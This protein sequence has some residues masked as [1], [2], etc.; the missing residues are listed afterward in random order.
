MPIKKQ[1]RD[2]EEIK[3]ILS[4]AWLNINVKDKEL[5]NPLEWPSSY[6]EEPHKYITWMLAQPEYF[7]FICSEI[8][9][10][11]IVPMQA[12]ILSE[13]WNRKFPMLIASRGAGKCITGDAYIITDSG[14]KRIGDCIGYDTTE[15]IKTNV[16]KRVYNE[17]GTFNNVEYSWNNGYSETINIKT[18]CGFSLEGTP[19]HPIRIVR[20]GNIRWVNL[21][22]VRIND[23]VPIDRSETWFNKTNN[24]PKDL[25]YMFGLLVGDGGYTVRGSISFT[26]KDEELHKKI[27]SIALKY[28]NKEF[29][30]NRPEPITQ[31]LYGVKIWDR[32]FN[33]FGFN[34][35][36][37]GEKDF[38]SSVLGAKKESVAAFI[39][40]LMDTDGTINKNRTTIEFAS[41]S[42]KLVH[43]LQ[44]VLT[45]FGIISSVKERLNKKY[46]TIYYYLYINGE[47]VKLFNDK[48]GFK[49]KRKKKILTSKLNTKFN[50]NKD[51]VPRELINST[52]N[53]NNL[54]FLY[55]NRKNISYK[56]IKK[57][58]IDFKAANHKY[59]YDKIKS[60]KK[61][62]AQTFDVHCKDDHSFI[63]NGIISHNTFLL[64]VYCL[65]R[66][67]LLPKRKLVIAGAAFRQS[68]FVFEYMESIW[69]NAP[70]LRDIVGA[71]EVAKAGPNHDTDM[72]TFNIGESKTMAI[73]IGDGSKIRGLRA[74]DLIAEEFDSIPREIYEVVLSGFASV[75][76]H[77]IDGVIHEASIEKA[78]ELGYWEDEEEEK[79]SMLNFKL[80]NQIVISGTAGYDF[81]TFGQYHAEYK[82]IIRSKG[83]TDR[84]EE[85]QRR[86]AQAENKEYSGIDPSFDWR[87]YSIIRIPVDMIPRG[88]MDMAVVARSKA[89]SHLGIYQMEYGA[90]FAKDSNGF[91]KRSLIESCTVSPNKSISHGSEDNIVFSGCLFGSQHR[92]YVYGVDPAF[93]TDNFSIIVVEMWPDHRRVIYSWTTNKEQHLAE[94]K[95]G[96]IDEQDF[97]A[98][99]AKK[100][101]SLMKRFPCEKIMMDSQGGG[102]AVLEALG[103]KDKIIMGEQ[104]I[105][106]IVDEDKPKP[107]DTMEGLHIVE[108]VN[109]ASAEWTG[110]ANH[111][112]RKDMEDK[113]LLFPYFD[114][115]TLATAQGLDKIG[116]KAHIYD[117]LEDCV[118]E[119]EE[120]K[121]ELVT[122]VMTQ[123]PS[124]RD[125]WDTPE[126]KLPGG[127]KGRMRKDRYS[128]LVMAN[129]GARN[130]LRTVSSLGE[131]I[132]GGWA[133][134]NQ[135]YGDGKMFYGNQKHSKWAQSFYRHL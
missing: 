14:F 2:N 73:P 57:Y 119:I 109:F 1:Y 45:R 121:K 22:D 46:N 88:F 13:L 74:N 29:S 24:L 51:I 58:N 49:L 70:I 108:L 131:F 91:F 59:Y 116:T 7:S 79:L 117:S 33:E 32:I 71:A 9:N 16:I 94:Q 15:K 34:S 90:C 126:I 95:A 23:Y 60:I 26:S 54:S 28:F 67:L 97:Y 83:D 55:N 64:G 68:K 101:R 69:Y 114:P 118:M 80:D 103:D 125:K 27:N 112:M 78:K 31:K 52:I 39:S 93:S 130:I 76:A 87:D 56:I 44:F 120:L 5:I 122:I 100:L 42:K 50:T 12:V 10:V 77:P 21:E 92:R 36:E 20:D 85:I 107:T 115:V 37:C 41:K 48:I 17:N 82:E 19:N 63:S 61:S 53:K 8:L 96:L 6:D 134:K 75:K 43:T 124:G 135:N 38:P 110:E 72:W 104:P 30:K 133:E 81:G 105:F 4:N 65:L 129:M 25:A 18:D 106:Q 98:Y 99:C 84:L 89:T 11:K 35:S 62:F 40:G 3:E 128:A 86:K 113:I 127:K 47:N 132:V 102:V 111:G 123:T 66:M